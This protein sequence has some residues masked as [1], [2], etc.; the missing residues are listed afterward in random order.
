MFFSPFLRAVKTAALCDNPFLGPGFPHVIGPIAISPYFLGNPGRTP[1]LKANSF[2]FFN[3][4][5]PLIRVDMNS[6]SPFP[7]S[8]FA[9]LPFRASL[10]VRSNISAPDAVASM[11]GIP[12]FFCFQPP[13]ALFF[14]LFFCT[15]SLPPPPRRL[16]PAE[17]SFPSPCF[18]LF[19]V[20]LSVP[21]ADKITSCFPFTWT[22]TSHPPLCFH[23]PLPTLAF[24]PSIPGPLFFP[25]CLF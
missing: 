17:N 6:P 9:I 16:P 8:G 13:F 1:P 19:P 5:G 14:S 4:F 18:L 12:F 11:C 21:F 20:S 3:D 15:N 22:T 2:F 7:H 24:P 10:P 23:P 25:K